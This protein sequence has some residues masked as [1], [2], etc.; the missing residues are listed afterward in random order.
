MLA[1]GLGV[2]RVAVCSQKTR[3]LSI[4]CPTAMDPEHHPS[5]HAAFGRGD[6]PVDN[7]KASIKAGTALAYKENLCVIGYFDS[8]L[9][10]S[11][12]ALGG[13]G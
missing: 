12:R 13:K 1:S 5:Q 11:I 6:N 4:D 2:A 3:S 9:L 10:N 8:I 7:L